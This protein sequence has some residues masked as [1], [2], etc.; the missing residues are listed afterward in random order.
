MTPSA[1]FA[2]EA[3]AVEPTFA[4]EGMMDLGL[5]KSLPG[6]RAILL[7]KIMAG[8]TALLLLIGI[9]VFSQFALNYER[10]I[11]TN[12]EHIV[13][14][15]RQAIRDGRAALGVALQ[16]VAKDSRVPA[17]LE[18][19]DAMGLYLVHKRAF[20]QLSAEHGLDQLQFADASRRVLIRMHRP[21][22]RGDV[23]NKPLYQE[24]VASR[25]PVAALDADRWGNLA[26]RMVK[27]VYRGDILVGFVEA[28]LAI[29]TVLDSVQERRSLD[30]AFVLGKSRLS[31]SGA[32]DFGEGMD[33]GH[34]VDA[35]ARAFV[36]TTMPSLDTAF[37]AGLAAHS[38]LNRGEWDDGHNDRFTIMHGGK[39]YVA[40]AIA[41]TDSL[42]F[43]FGELYV[44][45][46]TTGIFTEYALWGLGLLGAGVIIM[47]V[48]RKVIA[49]GLT[50]TDER[51]RAMMARISRSDQIFESVYNESETGFVLIERKSGAVMRA[52]KSALALFGVGAP[53]DIRLD[54]LR[55]LPAMHPLQQ[56]WLESGTAEP[57]M[58]TPCKA[59]A[60]CVCGSFFI[61]PE[62]EI[63][64]LAVR[65]VTRPLLLQNETRRHVVFLQGVID[66]LPSIV[67]IK[68][69]ELRILLCN[70]AFSKLFGNG[71]DLSGQVRHVG[72][73][74]GDMEAVLGDDREALLLGEPVIKEIDLRFPDGSV[75]THLAARRA[76]TGQDGKRYLLIV[77]TDITGRK[78]TERELIHLH[79][80]AESA[81]VAKSEFLASMSHEIRTPL[82]VILGMT[83]LALAAK[84]SDT[85]ANQLVKIRDAATRQLELVTDILE[86]AN[87]ETGRLEIRHE[88]FSLS[89]LLRETAE[90]TRDMIGG[91]AVRLETHFPQD[92][93]RLIGDPGRLSKVLLSLL[94]NA[95][96]FTHEGYVRL[97]CEIR[98]D[99]GGRAQVYFSIEDSGIGIPEERMD[100]LFTGFQQV[101]G[102]HNRQYGGAGLGLAMTRHLI[103]AMG[104]EIGL[105]S[106]EGA[107]SNFFFTVWM[108]KGGMKDVSGP[109]IVVAAPFGADESGCPAGAP[110]APAGQRPNAPCGDMSCLR[111]DAAPADVP[112]V[113]ASRVDTSLEQMQ[114][115]EMTGDI[116][117][118]VAQPDLPFRGKR[119]LVVED[120]LINQ[121]IIG[122]LLR[123]YGL[124]V[125]LA[126]DGRQALKQV[127]EQSFDLVLMDV[128][129]PVMDGLTATRRIRAMPNGRFAELPIVALTANALPQDRRDCEE[130]GMND[131]ISKPIDLAVLERKLAQWLPPGKA[132]KVV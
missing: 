59:E 27:P 48:S 38:V 62:A 34:W 67:C 33:A 121:E 85:L 89:A 131:F 100:R 53:E 7:P 108:Q 80:Q 103:H 26:L 78:Q 70:A 77:T 23:L 20:D 66:Q 60:Y 129:M 111:T 102:G 11:T 56:L 43:H 112:R 94:H 30:M 29:D 36:Y 65:D 126:G 87:A 117:A 64:C 5:H 44:I 71:E 16:L 42:G 47:L 31:R 118:S 35:G 54:L 24:A 52:N 97:T 91:K 46:D 58:T 132:Q 98:A 21:E 128:Q 115:V 72:W 73:T 18:S 39:Y 75:Y 79:A 109:D 13:R 50:R 1:R 57:L 122:E 40:N 63:E 37:A 95:V 92:P 17:L 25:A 49:A 9:G 10:R 124:D 68:D 41:L 106:A 127:A 4:W 12:H 113:E 83:Q 74:D 32:G 125:A 96:K 116:D 110:R 61:G 105:H 86:Y 88:Y 22:A 3:E 130:A 76:I 15:Y 104:G 99:D 82:N 114:P 120:N 14:L 28:G 107:G 51:I 81:S 19:G 123:G 6:V 55:P 2:S 119:V 8:M 101:D 69:S 93:A 45:E 90:A 84:P